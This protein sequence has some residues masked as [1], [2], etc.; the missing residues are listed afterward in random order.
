LLVQH[1]P[2]L[3]NSDHDYVAL[4]QAGPCPA[5]LDHSIYLESGTLLRF[6]D[7]D[8]RFHRRG[9]A[10]AY[11]HAILSDDTAVEGRRMIGPDPARRTR[12][13]FDGQLG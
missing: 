7:F 2:V 10:Q 3:V 6:V 12:L 5:D 11:L 9:L 1:I 13:N 8:I 4:R